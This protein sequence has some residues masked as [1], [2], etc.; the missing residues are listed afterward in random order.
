MKKRS[1]P[2]KRG[3]L[4][5]VGSEPTSLAQQSAAMLLV[6]IAVRELV[7]KERPSDSQISVDE[8]RQRGALN[9]FELQV[10]ASVGFPS[11]ELA[12]LRLSVSLVPKGD[13]K[14]FEVNLVISG[15][16]RKAPGQSNRDAAAVLNQMGGPLLFPFAREV[17]MNTVA[18]SIFGAIGIQPIRIGPLFSESALDEIKS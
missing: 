7:F 3:P 18:R 17:M 5:P 12:E 8:L 2:A 10:G 1:R 13:L 9:E 16:F 14:P 4:V 11:A 15:M 6:G